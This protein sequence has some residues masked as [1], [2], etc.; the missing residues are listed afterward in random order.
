MHGGKADGDTIFSD[1]HK[2]CQQYGIDVKMNILSITS[3]T[4]STMVAV[5]RMFE[6]ASSESN[7]QYWIG[8]FA[9]LVE[10]TTGDLFLE[11]I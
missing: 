7:P 11:Q 8:C 2:S 9:H 10:L 4:V 3:D 1:I 5:G 6:E